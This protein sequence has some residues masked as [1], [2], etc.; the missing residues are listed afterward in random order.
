MIE[1]KGII[2][3][4]GFRLG[5]VADNLGMNRGSLSRKIHRQQGMWLTTK[6]I[7]QIGEFID[8]D[9]SDYIERT[10]MELRGEDPQ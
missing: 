3:Q 10:E 2:W 5:A 8:C 4:K 6:Q 7:K 1:I 9:L